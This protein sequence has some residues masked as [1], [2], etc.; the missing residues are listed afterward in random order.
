MIA[1]LLILLRIN[2]LP[3]FAQS[4]L[5]LQVL[6]ASFDWWKFNISS[7]KSIVDERFPNSRVFLGEFVPGIDGKMRYLKKI[8]QRLYRNVQQ[9]IQKLAPDVP[10]YLCMESS[11]LWKNSM[12]NQPETA[13][14]MEGILLRSLDLL[15]FIL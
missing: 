11:P 10:A 4:W 5:L 15:L 7:L 2:G 9:K 3:T 13:P 14:E 6:F 8:R 1:D 12:P